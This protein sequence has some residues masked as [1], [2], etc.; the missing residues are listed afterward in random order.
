M[1]AHLVLD[2]EKLD[3]IATRL[4]QSMLCNLFRSVAVASA[5][6]CVTLA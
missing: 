1:R 2:E 3:A 5:F 4:R 6:K